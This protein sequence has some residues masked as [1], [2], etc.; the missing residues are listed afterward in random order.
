MVGIVHAIGHAIG[1]VCH[2]PHGDAMSMLLIP[3]MKFNLKTNNTL[4][5][6][7]LIYLNKKK[8]ATI[9]ED[10]LGMETIHELEEF[11]KQLHQK[12]SLPI[13]LKEIPDLKD[14]IDEIAE[15]ALNDG[16]L[17]VNAQYV[18]RKDIIDILDGQYGY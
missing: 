15:R 12:V 4:Y 1:A 6:D 2:I 17:L 7:L 18:T 16:A 5:G 9:D 10:S 3:C 14:R 13:S 11:L 8:Y